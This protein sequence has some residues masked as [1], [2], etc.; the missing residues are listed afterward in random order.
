MMIV[1]GEC[2][3]APECLN[4]TGFEKHC[5]FTRKM[6]L[7]MLR[8]FVCRGPRGEQQSHET[9]G[10]TVQREWVLNSYKTEMYV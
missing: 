10:Q 1:G 8:R 5:I 4:Y 6:G 9:A 7:T 2:K 3:V